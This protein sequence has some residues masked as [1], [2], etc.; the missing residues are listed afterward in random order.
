MEIYHPMKCPPFDEDRALQASP[1]REED[2]ASQWPSE[3]LVAGKKRKDDHISVV[4]E[5]EHSR[6]IEGKVT[7]MWF[8]V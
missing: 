4:G 8:E 1:Q 3:V 6:S 5:G 7:Q 2:R